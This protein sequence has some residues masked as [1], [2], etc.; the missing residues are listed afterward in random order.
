MAYTLEQYNALTAA[1][2]EGVMVVEYGDK[3]VQYRSLDEMIRIKNLMEADLGLKRKNKRTVAAF[4]K[5][6]Y[7]P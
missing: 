6:W 3:K 2:A 4:S 1:I 5:N 7:R